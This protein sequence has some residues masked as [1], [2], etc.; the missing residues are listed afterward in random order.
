MVFFILHKIAKEC[1]LCKYNCSTQKRAKKHKP[2]ERLNLKM[3]PNIHKPNIYA[4]WWVVIPLCLF[5]MYK[6]SII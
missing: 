3:R 6:C 2:T 5:Y 4:Y 1:L